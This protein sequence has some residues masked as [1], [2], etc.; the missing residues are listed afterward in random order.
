VIAAARRTHPEIRS[1]SQ[2]AASPEFSPRDHQSAV[3]ASELP[4]GPAAFE[5]ISI[6]STADVSPVLGFVET[7]AGSQGMARS[8]LAD[9]RLAVHELVTHALDYRSGP[10]RLHAWAT[11]EELIVEINSGGPLTSPFA[12]YL[13]PSMSATRERGLWL[14]GQRC[15]LIA[16]RELHERTTIRMQFF[17]YLISARPE[18]DGI[19]ELL[20][21]YAL[22]ACEPDEAT[23]IAAHLATCDECRAELQRLNEVVDSMHL[24]GGHDHPDG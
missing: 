23:L 9:L 7:F 12:G 11:P 4:A 1:R 24:R 15:D 17:D 20:G 3:R 14:A 10:A 5:Q 19:D 22:G 16:I 21:V 8:R 13:P 18:C 2:I 6:F